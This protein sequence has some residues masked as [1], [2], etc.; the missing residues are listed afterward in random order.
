M[1]NQ[2]LRTYIETQITRG[3][4]REDIERVLRDAGW[5]EEDIK[6]GFTATIP[7]C[8]PFTY[9]SPAY[10]QTGAVSVMPGVTNTPPKRFLKSFLFVLF[11]IILFLIVG[12]FVYA[13]YFRIP[14][15]QTALTNMTSALRSI[16]TFEYKIEAQIEG[17]TCSNVSPSYSDEGELMSV[18]NTK[19]PFS[20]KTTVSGVSDITSSNNPIHQLTFTSENTLPNEDNLSEKA[21]VQLDLISLQK[22]LYLKISKLIFPL[23]SFFDTTTFINKWISIDIKGVQQQFLGTDSSLNTEHISIEKREQIK[24]VLL[25]ANML[26]VVEV[27]EDIFQ[28]IPVYKYSFEISQEKQKEVLTHIYPILHEDLIKE[29]GS[30]AQE[31]IDAIAESVKNLGVI[32]GE[33]WVGKKDFLPYRITITPDIVMYDGVFEI[34]KANIVFEFKDYNVPLIVSAPTSVVMFD[35]VVKTLFAPVATTTSAIP[36]K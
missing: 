28:G 36:K 9:T 32:E 23:A 12:G 11:V 35:E 5:K 2:E 21:L 26:S 17:A 34:T 33:L 31:N 19:R 13:S 14:S 4:R 30:I 6:E 18:C 3:V 29:N 16:N 22:V 10:R 15:P 8:S 24:K 7:P 1:V 25:D 20:N 27:A